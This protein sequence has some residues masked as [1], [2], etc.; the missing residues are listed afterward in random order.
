MPSSAPLA[1]SAPA[2]F[3]PIL[4]DLGSALCA[5]DSVLLEC[6]VDIV[7]AR[8]RRRVSKDSVTGLE[9]GDARADCLYSTSDILSKNDRV[10]RCLDENSY[11]LVGEVNGVHGHRRV[12][13]ENVA[14][15][16]LCE[17]RFLDLEW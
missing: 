11:V 3:F 13:D 16:W 6:A 2:N 10:L 17:G 12:L 5:N 1:S 8:E 14:L 7:L 4:G 9:L 15:A